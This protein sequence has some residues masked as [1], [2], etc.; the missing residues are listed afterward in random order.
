MHC[1][2]VVKVRGEGMWFAGA[3]A[4]SEPRVYTSVF[5]ITGNNYIETAISCIWNKILLNEMNERGQRTRV[6]GCYTVQRSHYP[7]K[8]ELTT[9]SNLIT[10]RIYGSHN[11]KDVLNVSKRSV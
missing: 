2:S 10:V 9:L 7:L 6:T 11:M 1:E 8:V 5:E 4:D 3:E